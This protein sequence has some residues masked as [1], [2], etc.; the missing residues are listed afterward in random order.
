MR[1]EVIAFMLYLLDLYLPPTGPEHKRMILM[2]LPYF[3]Y[4]HRSAAAS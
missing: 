4:R 2:Y 1:A 3:L